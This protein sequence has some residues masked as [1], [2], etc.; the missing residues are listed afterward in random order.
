MALGTLAAGHWYLKREPQDSHE[1]GKRY[2]F[3]VGALRLLPLPVP[4]R[5]WQDLRRAL[6]SQCVDW[7]KELGL[8]SLGV[9]CGGPVF[10]HASANAKTIETQRW[11]LAEFVGL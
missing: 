11:I 6:R 5:R 10:A 9:I 8:V 3:K 4:V 2:A 1:F 7:A